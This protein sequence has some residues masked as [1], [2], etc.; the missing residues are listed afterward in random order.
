MGPDKRRE[1][2]D[3][4]QGALARLM[5]PGCPEG[6][7]R[8][9]ASL[10]AVARTRDFGPLEDGVVA[11]DTETTGLSFKSCELIE[12]AA[13]RIQ[14][15]E[16]V[17]R[18]ET[19]VDPGR[20]IPSEISALT[21]IRDIDVA[22]APTSEE[23]VA[24]LADFVGGMPVLAH[25][26]AFDRTF[27]EKVRGGRQVS[28]YWVDTLSLSRIALPLLTSHRLSDMAAAFGCDSVTHRAMDD[29]DALCGMWPVI[30]AGLLELPQG[31]VAKLAAMHGDVAWQ[32][33]PILSHIA[34]MND[35][36]PFSLKAA[37]AAL[38]RPADDAPRV[39]AA[40]LMDL[41]APDA[42]DIR[43]AFG[44]DG[45]AAAL[46]DS[47]EERPE[48]LAMALEVRDALEEGSHRAIEAGT[49]VG[50]SLAY[51]LPEI[52]FAQGNDVSVGVATKTNALAD[53]LVTRELP[54]LS[55]VLPRGVSFTSLKGYEHYLCLSRL[56]AAS[57]VELP[58]PPEG[59]T[60]KNTAR[61]EMLTAMAVSYA[62]AC[63]AQ[64]GDLDALG[65]RWRHVPRTM[66]T[67]TPQECLRAACPYFPNECLVHGA[68]R[69]AAQSDV[70]VTNHALLLR[71]IDM[72]GRILPPIRHWVIDEAHGLEAEARRQWA[73]EVSGRVAQEG[74]ERLGDT[75]GGTI[76]SLLDRLV[77]V[78]GSTL[79]VRLLTKLSATSAA[80]AQ[81]MGTL[82]DAIHEL[83][84][85]GRTGGYDTM[86]LWI[87]ETVRAT[88]EW[89]LVAE[90]LTCAKERMD[91]L[92]KDLRHGADALA[93]LDAGFAADLRAAA[94]FVPDLSASL[95][96]MARGDDKSFVYSAELSCRRRDRRGDALMARKIDV[97]A[98]LGERWL[99]QECSVVFTSATMTVSGSFDHFDHAVGLDVE[100]AGRHAGLSLGSSYDFERNMSVVIAQDMPVPGDAAYLPALE[101]LL[102]DVHRAMGGS[103]L[104]LFTNRRDME[105]LH[106]SLRPRLAKE[107]LELLCQ[108]RG[109]SPRRLRERFL[110]DEGC[111]LMAL[112][113][114][115]EGFDAAGDTLRCVVIPKLPFASPHDPL[116]RE[117]EL[118][119]DRAWW[120]HSLPE[121]VLS[122][123]QAAG[124]LIRTKS[125]V[126]VL[127]LA[128]SRLVSKRYGSQFVRSL[129]NPNAIRIERAH[130]ARYLETWRRSREG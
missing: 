130:M 83:G 13:A 47:F 22:G 84:G 21:H 41:R 105:R 12:I 33:R 34:S 89:R 45:L 18:F 44:P 37:R 85:L 112:K 76:R 57:L 113:S 23:A 111:S 124:R 119:E 121:A 15:K 98:D 30:L 59:G 94:A 88:Q 69:R 51:L 100:G 2:G 106:E 86:E 104:T 19:F 120:R 110:A 53:Q 101:E 46:Y 26:A 10:A 40:E 129:P 52:L 97:G 6:T 7:L 9:Y 65:I 99:S 75:K 66:L 93:E 8:R 72:E 96:L 1:E 68:R 103:T 3:A 29:V 108:E 54:A 81:A 64:D 126:G 95:G 20:P 61:S 82:V 73:R 60:S 56:D 78:S 27:V 127:V 122:T 38:R 35:P 71:D 107:G 32:F 79:Q 28:D 16:V 118:R 87:D 42:G 63:Q 128:D 5:T 114:F 125:D 11:L 43:R 58:S 102:F 70:V 4:G 49:G 77:A 109:S 91:E 50:K 14:G 123:K 31:L 17:E 115:W 55:R 36:A 39:D 62:F 92:D 74:F 80:A 24:R 90:A 117:R 116:V 48:Q 25:N 67:T